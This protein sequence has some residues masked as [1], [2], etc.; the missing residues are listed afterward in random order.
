M[1]NEDSRTV[2]RG[3]Q[4]RLMGVLTDYQEELRITLGDGAL[5]GTLDEAHIRRV[6]ERI[7]QTW[8]DLLAVQHRLDLC[9]S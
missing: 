8:A 3:R 4:S 7:S 6:G 5:F 1:M 9:R 2:L